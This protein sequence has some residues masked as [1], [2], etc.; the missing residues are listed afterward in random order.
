MS[1]QQ[2]DQSYDNAT[3]LKDAGAVV[4]DGAAQVLGAN[5]ILDLGLGRVDGRVIVDITAITTN[6]AAPENYV[7]K[8]EFSSSPTF[9]SD[10]VG[11]PCLFVGAAA[12][13]KDSAATAVGRYELPFLNEQN[14]T[15]RRYMRIFTEVIA[16]TAPSI[17]YTAFA[18]LKV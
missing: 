8:T 2:K 13:T 7:L 15:V 10:I 11:G 9:A 18:A 3:L 1:R 6:G 17:N 4:A 5:K 14:G 12:A 16:G